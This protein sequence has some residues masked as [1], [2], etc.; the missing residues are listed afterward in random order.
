MN[1]SRLYTLGV[2]RLI[3]LVAV[4]A[5]AGVAVA[6][7][8]AR[9]PPTP[10]PAPPPAGAPS[11]LVIVPDT[12]RAD[13]V[14]ATNPR[15]PVTPNMDRL[16]ARGLRF[17]QAWSQS[18]WTLPAL[19]S[20]LTGR[21]A[22]AP[23][24]GAGQALDFL[25]P[26]LPTLAETLRAGG[27][28]TAV[29][30]G[31]SISALAPEFS[32]GFDTVDR[33]AAEDWDAPL[34][35]WLDGEDRRPF[36]ALVHN[37]DL[38]FPLVGGGAAL[39][40]VD[41]KQGLDT[42]YGQIAPRLGPGSA[43]TAL[44]DAYDSTLTRYDEAVGRMVDG[45][46]ARGLDETVVIVTS[47]HGVD[48]GEHGDFRHGTVYSSCLHVPL[49]VADPAAT[50]RGEVD[51]IV[52]TVDLAPTVLER[53]GVRAETAFAGRTLGPLLRGEGSY[54]EREVY[55]FVNKNAISVRNRTWKV[56]RLRRPNGPPDEAPLWQVFRLP[57]DPQELNEIHGNMPPEARPMAQ[58]LEAWWA[59]REAEA[60]EARRAGS[61]GASLKQALK[62]R[63]YWGFVE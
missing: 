33:A 5:L 38:Q 27:Y 32:R 28:R 10:P 19:A 29:F 20:L 3:P 30:W 36:F 9:P 2:R 12:L 4:L 40:G 58:R 50:R 37:I 7:V 48:L 59:E 22:L 17:T 45:L 23:E 25:R 60:A 31:E 13:R 54:E 1:F 11:F 52:Q 46:S 14:G 47:N 61:V 26:D 39:D 51:T 49:I 24:D 63:G 41:R 53:A 43:A 57:D 35:R 8:L 56:A 15:G 18:G 62:E 34:L 55:S 16:A 21:F 42:I 6:F 44:R